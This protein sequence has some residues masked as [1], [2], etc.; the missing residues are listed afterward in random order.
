MP[1]DVIR[2]RFAAGLHNLFAYYATVADT[3]QLYDNSEVAGP[4]LVA[5][6]AAKSEPVIVD[7]VVWRTLRGPLQ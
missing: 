2:R 7:S 5:S 3:W 6:A 4:R 1:E